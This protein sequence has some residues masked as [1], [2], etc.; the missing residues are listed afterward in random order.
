MGRKAYECTKLSCLSRN[1][2]TN[3]WQ[4]AVNYVHADRAEDALWFSL[5]DVVVSTI[6]TGKV[7]Q[8]VDAFRL[9]ACGTLPNLKPITLRGAV[10]IDP[11]TQDLFKV[12]IEQRKAAASRTDL[13]NFEKKRLDKQLKVLANSTSYGIYAEMNPQES[14]VEEW[15]R[16]FGNG[17]QSIPHPSR[18][19]R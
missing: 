6:L 2:D 19:R 14:D 15:I 5:P 16:C 8:I 4:V 7:P 11:R 10:E 18:A 3:D 1:P 12:V 13:P 9:E 17:L